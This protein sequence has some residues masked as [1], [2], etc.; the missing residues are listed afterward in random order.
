VILL[1]VKPP[2]MCRLPWTTLKTSWFSE[3]IHRMI[4]P[5]CQSTFVPIL[6]T[7]QGLK[8]AVTNRQ[9]LSKREM[10]SVLAETPIGRSK[11]NTD[12][13]GF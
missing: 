4:R 8:A 3:K 2:V 10:H 9:G 12:T 13:Y 5:F 7:Q 11:V 6:N 1:G